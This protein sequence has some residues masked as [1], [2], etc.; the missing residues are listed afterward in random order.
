M[1]D[2]KGVRGVKGVGVSGVN[3]V[4]MNTQSCHLIRVEFEASILIMDKYY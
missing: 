2:V 4:G 3:G 1:S